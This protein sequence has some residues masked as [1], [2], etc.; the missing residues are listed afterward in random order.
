VRALVPVLALL[1]SG[2]L[3]DRYLQITSDPPGADVRVDDEVVGTT[4]VR[5]P[6]EHFGTRRITFYRAGYR[7]HSMLVHLRPRWYARF[8]LDILSE[9]LLPLGL[10]DR[11]KVHHALVPGEELLSLPSL[12]SVIERSDVLRHSGPE[13]PRDLPESVP[14]MIP[15]DS[16]EEPDPPLPE[17]SGP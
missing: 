13:G 2:C 10:R 1:L 17:G 5:V 9:V 7:T 3:V 12:R 4:P 14:A 16:G 8:P 6:F 11:R 15:S